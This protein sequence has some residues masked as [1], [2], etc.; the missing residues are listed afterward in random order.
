MTSRVRVSVNLA[1]L[2]SCYHRPQSDIGPL[3]PADRDDTLR[4]NLNHIAPAAETAGEMLALRAL[5]PVL[6]D[7][8]NECGHRLCLPEYESRNDAL[9]ACS[10]ISW[11][12][13]VGTCESRRMATSTSKQN[14]RTIRRSLRRSAQRVS[15]AMGRAYRKPFSLTT[16]NR[17]S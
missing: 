13:R 4:A 6:T 9:N 3:N 12:L 1:I 2:P 16:A 10:A 8:G 17:S 11:N 14:T 15:R 5:D 7:D